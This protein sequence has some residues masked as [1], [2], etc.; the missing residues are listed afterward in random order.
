MNVEEL[1][2]IL[3][4]HTLWLLGD[5]KGVKADLSGANLIGADLSGADLSVAN[6][7]GA[8]LRGA[9]LI[10]ANLSGAN[11]SGAN[12]YEANLRGADLSRVISDF[13]IFKSILGLTWNIV[14][15]DSKVTVGCQTH[16]LNKWLNFDD[17]IICEMDTKALT[18][19]HNTLK[20]LL[21]ET[22]KDTGL[23]NKG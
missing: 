3:N 22:Y 6:L 12:L 7:R 23:I 10:G 19:Y 18:F 11:L 1:K 8:N 13:K 2:D 15:M 20:P 16:D 5:A 4:K 17:E 14:L 9:N 21:L